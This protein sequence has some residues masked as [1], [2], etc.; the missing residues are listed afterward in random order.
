MPAASV[1]NP[2]VQYVDKNLLYPCSVIRVV[3]KYKWKIIFEHGE[4]L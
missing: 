4:V 1:Y 2:K 3:H